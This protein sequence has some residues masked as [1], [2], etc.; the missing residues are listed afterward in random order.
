MIMKKAAEMADMELA[1]KAMG[2]YK[3]AINSS[4]GPFASTRRSRNKAMIEMMLDTRQ[5]ARNIHRY[6]FHMCAKAC[7]R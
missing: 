4:T 7:L 6:P 1:R 3:S 5:L 2:K